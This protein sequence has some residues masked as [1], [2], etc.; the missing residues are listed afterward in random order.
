VKVAQTDRAVPAPKAVKSS[1]SLPKTN[2]RVGTTRLGL[3]IPAVGGAKDSPKIP[4]TVSHRGFFRRRSNRRIGV[5][6]PSLAV[7]LSGGLRAL[8]R[9][10]LVL[11]KALAVVAFV[12]AAAWGGRQAVRHV[13]AS[14]RFAV[15]EIRV[16]PMEHVSPD[17]IRALAGVRIGDRL[18]AVDPDAV[19]ARLTT[20]PWIL[21]A[22]VRRELP[23]AL[24][25]DVTERRAV[26]SALLGALYLLDDAGHPF[27]RA[28]FAEADGLPT[29][30]GISRDQYAAM[31]PT[32]EA[33]FREALSLLAVY[34]EPQA[35]AGE[36]P[37]RPPRPK[38]SEIH[39]D[40][41]VGFTAVLFDGGGEVHLGRGNWASK[42]SQL[43]RIL[44]AIGPRG[45]TALATVYLDGAPSDRV[46]IRLKPGMA[47]EIAP[48]AP[49][50]ASK[51]FRVADKRGED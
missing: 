42:L 30:T 34:A 50:V 6:R 27:K 11:G 31:R 33:V 40:P 22:R 48:P 10:L 9:K 21:A 35:V 8:G 13:I 45:P 44:A 23:S 41:R 43:D 20:H 15:R 49:V 26:A 46:T 51:K 3:A 29:L 12:A 2:S 4:K 47:P 7:W 25:V 28:T 14:P 5:S 39:V 24:T 18:L 36:G 17:E 19:A 1:V 32:S 38:L 16:G 37:A